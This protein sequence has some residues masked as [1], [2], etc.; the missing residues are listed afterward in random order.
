MPA[1]G[2]AASFGVGTLPTGAAAPQDTAVKTCTTKESVETYP[3]RDENGITKK[4]LAGKL[5]TTEVTLDLVGSPS[6]AAVV[7]GDF[8]EG[9]LKQV[10][11][12]LSQSNEGAPEGS[13]TFKAYETIGSTP[14]N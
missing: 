5:K 13:V 4:L 7:A 12:K 10:S 9:T 3:Y 1:E 8:T 2:M 14:Q 6:L 11:A